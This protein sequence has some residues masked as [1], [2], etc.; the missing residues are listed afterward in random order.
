MKLLSTCRIKNVYLFTCLMM[1]PFWG[2]NCKV[3]TSSGLMKT[4]SIAAKTPQLTTQ[5]LY[6][7]NIYLSFLTY[8]MMKNNHIFND[9][10]WILSSAPLWCNH[11][12]EN[13]IFHKFP[14]ILACMCFFCFRLWHC[15]TGLQKFSFTLV[16]PRPWTFGVLGALWQNFITENHCLKENQMWINCIKYL[17]KTSEPWQISIF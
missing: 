14:L 6:W 1:E 7:I 17:G 10:G 12:G 13:I 15:G 5:W 2:V 4:S 8:T 9:K 3:S 16:M 11:S